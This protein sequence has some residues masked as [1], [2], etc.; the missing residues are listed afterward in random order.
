MPAL[1][2]VAV[3]L[4]FL[5]GRALSRGIFWGGSEPST[6]F[7]SLSVDGWSCVPVL[8]AVWPKEF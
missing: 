8:L 1:W 6:T 3:G 4:V 7:G 2:W 5:V